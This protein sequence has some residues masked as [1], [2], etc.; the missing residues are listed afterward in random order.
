MALQYKRAART[1]L[2]ILYQYVARRQDM[3][4]A[5]LRH[6]SSA[7]VEIPFLDSHIDVRDD[8]LVVHMDEL[9]RH[10]SPPPVHSAGSNVHSYEDTH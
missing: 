4:V 6:E 9:A 10:Q 8:G 2:S 7:I 1:A 3:E 5:I